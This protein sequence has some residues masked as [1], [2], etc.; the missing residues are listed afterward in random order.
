MGNEDEQGTSMVNENNRAGETADDVRLSM[1]ME[2]LKRDVQAARLQAWLRA[3]QQSLMVGVVL[4]LLAAIGA[5]LWLEHLRAQKEAAATLYHQ[6]IAQT[7]REKRRAVLEEVTKNY[8][9]TAYALLARLQLAALTEDPRPM[10]QDLLEDEDVPLAMRWQ[11]RLDLAEYL[12]YQG[13]KDAVRKWL[14][15]RMG[16][17][18]E[19]LRY[20]LLA[21]A[22]DDDEQ[23][24][25]YLR[26]SLQAES[27]DEELK[28]RVA[29]ELGEEQP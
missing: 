14:D 5:S 21:E 13:E 25:A 23:R 24:K 15:T 7:D 8:A 16:T 18:Y 22:S 4:F 28:D 2:E 29:A 27:H 10:L 1:E 12:L 19:Q 11:A 3:H 9:D 20:Y 26:K 6:A 17:H